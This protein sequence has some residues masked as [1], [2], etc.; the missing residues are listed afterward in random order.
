MLDEGFR[1]QKQRGS[2]PSSW[3]WPFPCGASRVTILVGTIRIPRDPRHM[4]TAIESGNIVRIPCGTDLH[5]RHIEFLVPF[6]PG[7]LDDVGFTRRLSSDGRRWLLADDLSPEC[8]SHARLLR[9]KPPGPQ[10]R[11]SESDDR[12]GLLLEV[13][14]YRYAS[15]HRKADHQPI[16][17][18]RFFQELQASCN[19]EE[20]FAICTVGLAFQASNATWRASLLADP[21]EIAELAGNLGRIALAGIAL[22]F[23][24]SAM[25]LME[26][27]LDVTPGEDEY[28]AN[29]KFSQTLVRRQLSN[30]YE[31]VLR[32]AERLAA[33]FI[34]AS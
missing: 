20:L 26:A 24:E 2:Q 17:H 6:R 34:T 3:F 19:E 10:A 29:L 1:L 12:E 28:W 32:K 4:P 18:D 27:R 14:T 22:R 33:V 11:D 31:M 9:W 16:E 30:S 21:P 23:E 7:E 5:W 25:G 15:V 8:H 13:E